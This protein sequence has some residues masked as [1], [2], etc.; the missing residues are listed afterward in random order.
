MKDTRY[1]VYTLGFSNRSWETTIQ[2]L[3]GFEIERLVDIRTLPGSKHT[4]QFNREHLRAALPTVAVEYIHLK[5]LGRLRRPRSDDSANTAWKNAGFRGYADFMQT[6]D[7]DRALD[8]L[9]RLFSERRSAYA[10]TEAVFWRCHRALVSD[11]LSAHRFRVGHI[12]GP[13]QSRSHRMTRFAHVEGIE[14]TYP[15]PGP[16][17]HL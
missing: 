5:S 7:F 13:N 12:F 9:V 17:L 4:P 1:D 2:I 6:A 16:Q 11:A 3:H 10:C 15:A 8:D 14:V